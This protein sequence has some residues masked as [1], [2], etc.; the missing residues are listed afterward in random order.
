MYVELPYKYLDIAHSKLF[1]VEQVDIDLKVNNVTG[2][3][4]QHAENFENHAF[5]LI[6]ENLTE[7]NN[8]V[9]ANYDSAY[10]SFDPLQNQML[11]PILQ[12]QIEELASK[13]A[14][15]TNIL[16]YVIITMEIV[17]ILTALVTLPIF[18]LISKQ[19]N[20]ILGLFT[21]ISAEKLKG[22]ITDLHNMITRA[23]HI[24]IDTNNQSKG[25]ITHQSLR[26]QKNGKKKVMSTMKQLPE[27]SIIQ[28]VVSFIAVVLLSIY[29][30]TNYVLTK[31][32]LVQYQLD[33]KL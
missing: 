23:Q 31:S 11:L 19:R 17:V 28:I 30:F 14:N 15:L 18:Q 25:H 20:K 4:L 27:L 33:G 6:R 1:V 13:I 12:V 16:I 5:A 26:K 9:L 7:L 8:Y 2:Y 32:L 22:K 3:G 29:P 24:Q 21:T 10:R